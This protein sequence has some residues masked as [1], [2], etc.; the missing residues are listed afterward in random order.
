[1]K[2]LKP[3]IISFILSMLL[4]ANFCF[5]TVAQAQTNVNQDIPEGAKLIKT[6]KII[7]DD[8]IDGTIEILVETYEETYDNAFLSSIGFA[9]K[10]SANIGAKRYHSFKITNDQLTLPS[11]LV[12]TGG[13]L[14][15]AM[16]AKLAAKIA[17]VISAK[18]LAVAV[19]VPF[20]VGEVNAARG[21]KGFLV[22]L[23]STYKEVCSRKDGYCKTDWFV[24]D[25]SIRSY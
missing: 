21:Q 7:I 6:K 17:A 15:A 19:A 13:I 9:E 4:I 1:M 22:T 5:P 20:L 23:T 12:G 8:E 10:L 3:K 18:G 2:N 11:S 14:T 16:N 25:I 24:T